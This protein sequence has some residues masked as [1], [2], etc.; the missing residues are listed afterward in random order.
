MPGNTGPD[1][2]RVFD[3]VRDVMFEFYR[4][5]DIYE[6]DVLNFIYARTQLFAKHW[7]SI[8]LRHFMEGIVSHEGVVVQPP[9]CMSET[10]LLRSIKYLT[11]KGILEV[12]KETGAASQYRIRMFEEVSMEHISS[13]MFR[14][15]PKIAQSIWGRITRDTRRLAAMS[16]RNTRNTTT[17]LGGPPPPNSG[18]RLPPTLGDIS[19]PNIINPIPNVAADAAIPGRRLVIRKLK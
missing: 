12:R 14:H 7:E 11:E 3:T 18:G 2:S 4:F 9:V 5:C 19:I 10:N 1:W 13:Y 16:G 17:N 6:R 15:Q 8:P